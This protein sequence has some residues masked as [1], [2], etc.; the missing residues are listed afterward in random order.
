MITRRG[1]NCGMAL[2]PRLLLRSAPRL[3]LGS[4]MRASE[5]QRDAMA[6]RN[7]SFAGAILAKAAFF[8]ITKEKSDTIGRNINSWF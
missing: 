4:V 6:V 3:R 8:K 1:G 5:R 2:G 7:S